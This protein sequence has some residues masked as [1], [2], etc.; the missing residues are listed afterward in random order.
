MIPK[1]KTEKAADKTL[2]FVLSSGDNDEYPGC[3][4]NLALGYWR[5]TASLPTIIRPFRRVVF[6]SW[7]AATVKR[8]GRNWYWNYTERQYGFY[9]FENH[10][11]ILYG[12]Q[13][14]DSSTEQRWSCFLPWSEWRHIRHSIYD[15][16]GA[17]FWSSDKRRDALGNVADCIEVRKDPNV[18]VC[19]KFLDFDS[20][21][22]EVSTCIE[23]REWHKGEGWFKWL[24]WFTSPRIHR[25]LNL[26]FSSETGPRKGSWKGGT[27]GH[28]IEMLPGEFH[29]SAF[30]RYCQ[31]HNMSFVATA[32]A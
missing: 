12:R 17:L 24:S 6:A 14:H 18:A 8:L 19:F 4:L 25:S 3:K 13:S 30:R 29:E 22:I 27:T 7:D 5:L 23:E 26:E 21:A 1:V 28:S 32:T 9:L 20:E 10:F 16:A 11:N 31:Q 15:R 2:R